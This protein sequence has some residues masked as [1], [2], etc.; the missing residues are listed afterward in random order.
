MK[1][2]PNIDAQIENLYRERDKRF[3]WS[4]QWKDFNS[5]IVVLKAIKKDIQNGTK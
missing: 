4:K 3:R 2:T 1:Q 5:Q